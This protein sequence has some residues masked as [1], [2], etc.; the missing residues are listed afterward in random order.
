MKG[1]KLWEKTW[2]EAEK[3]LNK[4]SIVVLPIG[5]GS[6]EHGR[7]LPLGTDMMVVDEIASRLLEQTDIILLPTLNY[8]FYPAFINWPGSISIESDNFR[9]FAGD[10]IESIARFG[11]VKFMILDGGISTHYPLTILSYEL[12][13]K[14]G[15][16]VAVTDISGLG[17]EVGEEICEQESGGHADE[18]ETSCILII[19]PDLVKMDKAVK[20]YGTSVP[21]TFSSAGVKKITLKTGMTTKNGAHGDPT[22]ATKEKG[23]L[24]IKAMTDDLLVFLKGFSE[25]I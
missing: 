25:E 8:A 23:E 22:L 21:G 14:L 5:G 1:T 10:I 3:I 24:I 17:K 18:S 16:K 7:H 6:K 15:I 9:K 19:R 13:N 2:D 11:V 12:F 4:D 20:E